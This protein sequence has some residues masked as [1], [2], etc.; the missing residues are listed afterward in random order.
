MTEPRTEP[1]IDEQIE[2]AFDHRG[3]V[4]I[5]FKSGESIEAFLF[6]RDFAPHASLRESPFVEVFLT[7]GARK[8]YPIAT[9]ETVVLSGRD[10]ASV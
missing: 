1:G 7:G 10:H 3:N 2:A 8:K 4:T 5:T 6:N 9:I